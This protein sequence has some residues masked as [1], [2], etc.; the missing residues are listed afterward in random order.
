MIEILETEEFARWFNGLRTRMARARID[1][2]IRGLALGKT[3]GLRDIF[4]GV[5]EMLVPHGRGYRVYLTRLD[6]RIILLMAGAHNSTLE[7]DIDIAI[8]WGR[9]LREE[10]KV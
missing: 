6:N 2:R 10:E 4:P 1:A 3:D 9:S 5:F 7:R 8:S